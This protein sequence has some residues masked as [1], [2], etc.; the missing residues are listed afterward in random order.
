MKHLFFVLAA[1]LLAAA[2]KPADTSAGS[3]MKCPGNKTSVAGSQGAASCECPA[4]L[5]NWNATTSLCAA[6]CTGGNTWTNNAC[7]CPANLP[8]WNAT[9]SLCVAACASGKVWANNA[10][11][12]AAGQTETGGK[13]VDSTYLTKYNTAKA[14]LAG[15]KGT[16]IS[17]SVNLG[18]GMY[19]Y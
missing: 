2:G 7:S 11:S 18:P 1:F 6:A 17:G 16:K 12:C 8:N 14:Y 4:N 15:K 10:C 5:P 19:G 3:C 9:T 13:C